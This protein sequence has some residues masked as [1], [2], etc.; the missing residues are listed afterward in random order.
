MKVLVIGSEGQLGLEFQKIS[1]NSFELK[2]GKLN[3][4]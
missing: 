3:S 2:N 4:I 1:N